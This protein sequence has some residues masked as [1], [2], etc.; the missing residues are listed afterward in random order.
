[1]NATRTG[2]VSWERMI[3]AV[4]KVRER[5]LRASRALEAAGVP[6][7]VADGNA[8]A[9]WVSTVDEGAVRNTQ[10]VDILLR[11]QDLHAATMA[12]A[13]AGFVHRRVAGLDLF[14][15]GE[16]TRARDAVHV[17]FAGEKV[18]PEHLAP[19]PDV[20]RDASSA[21]FSL[22]GL[23]SLVRMKLVA[24]RDKDRVHLRDLADVGL[25]DAS[26]IDRY[27]PE[28]GD[29]LRAVLDSPDG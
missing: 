8:V 26:W 9:A 19:A 14:L 1:V 23:E 4:E 20:E 28:L 27:G 21:S 6:Y 11:R 5:L 24:W 15:D 22:V 25:I 2:H 17:I 3:R 7:C 16:G 18:R 10:D 12:L 13:A 29:R